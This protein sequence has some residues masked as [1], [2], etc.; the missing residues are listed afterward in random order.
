ML[1]EAKPKSPSIKFGVELGYESG[2]LTALIV[3]G[4]GKANL[5]HFRMGYLNDA[6]ASLAFE[7][8]I[9]RIE[10]HVRRSACLG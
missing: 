1:D 3:K 9:V 10:K 5:E 8:Y 4:T 7:D 6:Q 2:Q